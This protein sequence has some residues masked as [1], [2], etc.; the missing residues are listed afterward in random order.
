[1]LITTEDMP[2]GEHIEPVLAKLVEDGYFV[3]LDLGSTLNDFTL[4]AMQLADFNYVVTSGE[5]VANKLTNAFLNAAENLG[6]RMTDVLPIVNDLYG[7][8]EGSEELVR[9]PIA[10]IPQVNE[11]SRLR[12]W[13][14]E[15]GVQKLMSVAMSKT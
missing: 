4:T 3:V 6:L 11:R 5:D 7:T 8:V 10:H 15:P 13:V 12:L 1:M 2:D 9:L 14:K